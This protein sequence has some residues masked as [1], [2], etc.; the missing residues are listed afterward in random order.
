MSLVY[1]YCAVSAILICHTMLFSLSMCNMSKFFKDCTAS[2]YY[3][4]L[5]YSF[6]RIECT[7]L[8]ICCTCYGFLGLSSKISLFCQQSY[9]SVQIVSLILV[10]FIF[11]FRT[12]SECDLL[13]LL[14]CAVIQLELLISLSLSKWAWYYHDH[15]NLNWFTATCHYNVIIITAHYVTRLNYDISGPLTI[16]NHTP[17][18]HS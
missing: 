6:L 2:L 17:H 5:C 7:A 15:Y 9:F 14:L 8:Y 18:T 4:A 13:L 12:S 1:L 16:A 11:T 3:I 10:L